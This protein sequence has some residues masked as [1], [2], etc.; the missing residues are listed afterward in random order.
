MPILTEKRLKMKKIAPFLL[1]MGCSA[2]AQNTPDDLAPLP[3][4]GITPV[5]VPYADRS[6]SAME[7]YIENLNKNYNGPLPYNNEV[8]IEMGY[9]WCSLLLEGKN[10][11]E[12]SDI[13]EQN[14]R[15]EEEID[16]NRAIIVNA[17]LDLCPSN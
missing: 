4:T 15:T 17:Y 2:T 8:L 11:A 16:L 12:V 9:Y 13:M 3:T 1:L 10:T 5:S 14:A 6:D 7:R